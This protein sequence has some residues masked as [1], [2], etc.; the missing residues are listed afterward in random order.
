MVRRLFQLQCATMPNDKATDQS[1]R[2]ITQKMT[3]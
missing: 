1:D 2:T 3:A